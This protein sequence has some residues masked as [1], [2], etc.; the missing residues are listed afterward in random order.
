M[1]IVR[2][3]RTL[4]GRDLGLPRFATALAETREV[5]DEGGIAGLGQPARIGCGHLFFHGQPRS[6]G[7]DGGLPLLQRRG[8]AEEAANERSA[9]TVKHDREFEEHGIMFQLQLHLKS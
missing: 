4:L 9:V 2:G 6:H 1:P 5:E 3:S 7:D 8:V